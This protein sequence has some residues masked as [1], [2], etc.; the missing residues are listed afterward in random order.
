M[1][2]KAEG[3]DRSRTQLAKVSVVGLALLGVTVIA[4]YVESNWWEARL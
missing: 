4:P 2:P 1:K 3:R